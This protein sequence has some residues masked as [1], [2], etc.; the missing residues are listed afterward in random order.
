MTTVCFL[1]ASGANYF[2]TEV[3]GA[4]EAATRRAG[5]PTQTTT[6]V[7]PNP[8]PATVYV[9][10]PHE[11]F[12]LAPDYGRPAPGQLARTVGLC[13]EQPGTDE[14]EITCR[15]ASQLGGMLAIHPGAA[16]ELVRREIRATHFPLG[17]VP[18]WDVWGG[19]NGARPIDVVYLG[20]HEHRRA[21]I[22]AA[23]GPTLSERNSRLVLAR[24]E[25]KPGP[26]PSFVVGREKHE[27]LSSSKVLLNLHREGAS[28]LEWVRAIEAI[29]NGAVVVSE[30]ARDSSPLIPGEHYISGRAAE[31][32]LLADGL[33]EDDTWLA[34]IRS[35]AY[36]LIREQLP[37]ERSIERL[38]AVAEKLPGSA[39]PHAVAVQALH[40]PAPETG[41]LITAALQRELA[42]VRAAL[43]GLR[44]ELLGIRRGFSR[45]E[46]PAGREAP[47]VTP[48]VSAET[49]AYALAQPRVSVLISLYNYEREILDALESVA[50]SEHDSYDVLILDD[51]SADGS[52]EVVREFLA[53]RRWLPA[54]LLR[55]ASNQGVSRTR[56]TLAAL[57]RGELVFVLDADNAVYPSTLRKLEAALDEDPAAMFAFSLCAVWANGE[58]VGLTSVHEWDP[59]QLRHENYIDAM[60]MLRRE[61]LLAIGGYSEDPR[62][63]GQED[64]DLW[65]RVADAG[66]RGVHVPE[67]L[68]VYHRK[69]HGLLA[70][71]AQIDA[72]VSRSLIM[73]RAPRLF[74]ARFGEEATVAGIISGVGAAPV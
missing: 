48:T 40:A 29:C 57:A 6:D 3:L 38:L 46:S 39:T 62:L 28:G 44:V 20:S 33:L 37:I 65:C 58:P 70:T 60:A 74:G 43:K 63:T 17:Y 5:I 69:A 49:E 16:R 11:F 68:G 59:E 13:V 67:V 73:S 47:P 14:F 45:R 4:V 41:A 24:F 8:S 42:P 23:Y 71:V 31:L 19:G 50:A 7:Y 21:P 2:M 35:S 36:E 61:R 10:I 1:Y 51:A 34:A 26:G 22:I 32:A 12:Q 54:R 55:H 15:F 18:E 52:V 30:H 56:N 27:L 72:S 64:Y 53:Q 66:L 25:P 9:S